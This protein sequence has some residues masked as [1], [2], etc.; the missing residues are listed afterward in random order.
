MSAEDLISK[1]GM[2]K[3][4]RPRRNHKRSWIAQ[5]P[6]HNDVSPSLYVD[7]GQS[8]NVL[9]KCWAGCGAQEVA[10][11]VGICMSKLFPDTDY[12]CT[13]I[14]Q[15]KDLDYHELHLQISENRRNKGEKQTLEDKQSE[16]ES[17]MA[18][19]GSN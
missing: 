1:L 16:L 10:D 14:K 18:L 7:E 11:S 2:V 12:Q 8:G 4:V 19:R 3:E 17:F 15:K 5:C 13:T 9:I 6:S